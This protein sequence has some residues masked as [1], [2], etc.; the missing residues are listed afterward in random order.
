MTW[1]KCAAEGC[2]RYVS[3]EGKGDFHSIKCYQRTKNTEKALKE[4]RTIKRKPQRAGL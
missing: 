2:N 4:G 3:N 1:K